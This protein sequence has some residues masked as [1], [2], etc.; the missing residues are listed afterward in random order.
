M[1]DHGDLTGVVRIVGTSDNASNQTV[2]GNNKFSVD[3]YTWVDRAWVQLGGWKL[4]YDNSI[5]NNKGTFVGT[6][7]T[8]NK[9]QDEISF[10]WTKGTHGYAIGVTDPRDLWG[11]RLPLV[12]NNPQVVGKFTF[13]GA[14]GD[15]Q[16]SAGAAYMDPVAQNVAAAVPTTGADP[17]AQWVWGAALGATIK[18]DHISKGDQLQLATYFGDGGCFVSQAGNCGGTYDS[19]FNWSALVAFKHIINSMWQANVSYAY[20]SGWNNAASTAGGFGAQQRQSVG[21]NLVWEPVKDF[22]IASRVVASQT[23]GS[24]GTPWVYT[25]QIQFQWTY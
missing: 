3:R 10:N 5:F 15:G 20:L 1:T 25:G 9:A 22:T 6:A 12:N 2:V 8:G 23:L 17:V 13:R 21:A 18:A 19:K 24:A 14:W 4:G 11:T 7:Y 16:V